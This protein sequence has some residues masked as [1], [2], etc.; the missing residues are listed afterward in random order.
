MG[1]L[2]AVILGL[3]FVSLLYFAKYQL[4]RREVIREVENHRG[5]VESIRSRTGWINRE[6]DV[7]YMDQN[8]KRCADTC[9][10]Q[11]GWTPAVFWKK[12]FEHAARL[13]PLPTVSIECQCGKMLD[14]DF[15]QAGLVIRCPSC[16]QEVSVPSRFDLQRLIQ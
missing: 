4:D 8:G 2:L 11:Q 7:T 1:I 14:V 3:A 15:S 5:T 16:S 10:V 6:W 9:Y 13:P 12:G